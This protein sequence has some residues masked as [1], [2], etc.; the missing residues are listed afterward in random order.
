MKVNVNGKKVSYCSDSCAIG[1]VP[2]IPSI[3]IN[4]KDLFSN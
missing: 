2:F 3:E 4:N 1:T